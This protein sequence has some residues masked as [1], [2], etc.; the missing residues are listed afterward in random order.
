MEYTLR[1][2]SHALLLH[3]MYY[4]RHIFFCTNQRHDGSPCCQ[5]HDAE[6]MRAYAKQR[7]KALGIA[8]PGQVRVNKSGCMDRCSEGPIAVVYPEGV[9]Y[10]YSDEDD[11]EEI[12]QEHL[13]N[14]RVVERLKI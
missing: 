6:R 7:V 8:G 12:V 3:S 11:V 4:R 5:N 9:W 13:L 14:G 10:S 1:R 2:G